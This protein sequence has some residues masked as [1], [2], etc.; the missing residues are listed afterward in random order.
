M[1]FAEKSKSLRKEKKL[2]QIQLAE[3]LNL[4]KAC[5]SISSEVLRDS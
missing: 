3:A 1:T 2:S 5:I 4:S